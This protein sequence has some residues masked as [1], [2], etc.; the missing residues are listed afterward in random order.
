MCHGPGSLGRMNADVHHLNEKEKSETRN[1][2]DA[3]ETEMEVTVED[4]LE[5]PERTRKKPI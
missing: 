4:S 2:R 3:T 5:I 1:K